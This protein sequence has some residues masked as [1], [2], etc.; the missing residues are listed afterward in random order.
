VRV[1]PSSAGDAVDTLLCEIQE[2]ANTV[3]GLS[4]SPDGA[5]LATAESSGS[6][7]RL[8]L[9][10]ISPQTGEKRILRQPPEKISLLQPVFSPDGHNIVYVRNSDTAVSDVF[11]AGFPSGPERQIT[12]DHAVIFGLSWSSA[13]EII[14]S[15][16][17]G[18]L[19]PTLWRVP[20]AGAPVRLT[21][22]AEDSIPGCF[23]GWL[24]P[25][26]FAL[27]GGH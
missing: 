16:S 15:S 27:D 20:L 21:E 13:R 10:L 12:F 17:R 9:T 2:R 26:L 7:G 23:E 18:G 19:R 11:V 1:S 8:F 6:D 25:G 3:P 14:V 4:W 24:D 5:W 22:G